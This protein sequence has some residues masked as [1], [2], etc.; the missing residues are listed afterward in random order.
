MSER[1]PVPAL[2]VLLATTLALLIALPLFAN[3]SRA[4]R[5]PIAFSHL[6]H[7]QDL[8]L[9]CAF[10]HKY[11]ETGA[12][13][14]LP[15]AE[16]C[17]ICHRVPLGT[18]EAAAELTRMIDAEEPLRFNKLFQ[19]PDHVFYTH[20]RHVGIAE[21]ECTVCHGAIAETEAPPP[22]PLVRMSMEYCLGCHRETEQTVDCNACHR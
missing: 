19:L 10:C 5:Q 7:T 15:A 2:G 14:G 4:V 12:H 1:F 20:R 3:R 11:V 18:T 8:G 6:R 9:E 21:I 13:S 16:T 17:S 22:R